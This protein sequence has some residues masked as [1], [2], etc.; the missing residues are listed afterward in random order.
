MERERTVM[1]LEVPPA[2]G[3]DPSSS[4]PQKK[5]R[6]ILIRHGKPDIKQDLP[7][8]LWPL[9]QSALTAVSSLAN[10]LKLR[11]FDIKGIACSPEVKAVA[12][13]KTIAETLAPGLEVETNPDLA[14][15]KRTSTSFLPRE[16]FEGKIKELFKTP[17]ILVFGEET[18]DEAFQRFGQA[19]KRIEGKRE[20]NG[21]GGDVLVATHGTVISIFV[22]RRLG[23]DPWTFWKELEMPMAIVISEEEMEVIRPM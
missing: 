20:G 22:S 17:G 13:A 16:E 4:I 9:S 12:T 15:H 6:L 14:E 11:G 2:L 5:S 10:K 8:S 19:V 23:V 1:D 18:A 3:S 21:R 7:S